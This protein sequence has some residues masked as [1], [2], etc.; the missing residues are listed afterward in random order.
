MTMKK[1]LFILSI[2]SNVM[3][4]SCGKKEKADLVIINGKV[5]T[6]DQG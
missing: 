1:V 2:Q 6:I 3:S 5:L 4:A